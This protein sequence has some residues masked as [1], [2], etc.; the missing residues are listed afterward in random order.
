MNWHK[1]YHS[2]WLA[3]LTRAQLDL[4]ARGLYRDLLD[5]HYQE[6]GIPDNRDMLIRI[7]ATTPS[8]FDRSWKHIKDKFQPDQNRPGWLVNGKAAEVL[9]EFSDYSNKQSDRAKKGWNTKRSRG[10]AVAMPHDTAVA[11]P[12]ETQAAMHEESET[13][14]EKTKPCASPNGNARL[15][16]AKPSI[17]NP[18]FDTVE[19]VLFSEPA[20]SRTQPGRGLTTQQESWF[21]QWWAE[22]WLHKAKKAARE[23]FRKHVQSEARF[24]QI[25]AAT[26]SQRPEMISRE[27]SKRPHGATWLNGERWT[28]EVAATTPKLSPAEAAVLEAAR[29]IEEEKR[30][31]ER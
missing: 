26:R 14:S 25:M 3:S 7:A 1:W 31:A 28:D 24:Q 4:A 5:F 27:P 30:H 17:E 20:P 15:V 18:A 6:R 22:Y 8:E 11:M 9:G 21:N 12:D 2:T 29:R 19:P 10:N 23:A 16:D 13:E